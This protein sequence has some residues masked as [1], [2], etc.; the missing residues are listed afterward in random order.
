MSSILQHPEDPRWEEVSQY[1]FSFKPLSCDPWACPVCLGNGGKHKVPTLSQAM[2]SLHEARLNLSTLEAQRE[3]IR[4]SDQEGIDAFQR[5]LHHA[6]NIRRLE[7]SRLNEATK[8]VEAD[9]NEWLPRYLDGG[10]RAQDSPEVM[11][12]FH[13]WLAFNK[14]RPEWVSE[15]KS[16]DQEYDYQLRIRVSAHEDNFK[17]QYIELKRDM[18][19]ARELDAKSQEVIVEDLNWF[20]NQQHLIPNHIPA[21]LHLNETGTDFLTAP[22]YDYN[23]DSEIS[24]DRDPTQEAT[25]SRRALVSRR[26][27]SADPS[28]TSRFKE[29]GLM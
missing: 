9:V 1:I 2:H 4:S 20:R 21:H 10:E 3:R 27:A 5:E 16:A 23:A 14:K 26:F 22:C 8:Q 13:L 18:E 17:A 28:R 6:N 11:E 7:R 12:G 29:S 15:I 24:T 19:A 25:I